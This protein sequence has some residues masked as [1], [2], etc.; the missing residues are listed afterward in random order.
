M[1]KLW[2]LFVKFYIRTGFAFYFKRVLV[3]G[4][5]N[6]PK[7]KA[8]LFV[9]NHQNALI[10]PL[11]IGSVSPRELNFLTRADVFNKRLVRWL[12][13]TVNMLPIYRIKDGI[14]SLSRN[15]EVFE[16]C[17]KILNNKGTVLIFPEGNHNI[18]R[19]LRIL[20]KGFTRIIFGTLKINPDLEIVVVPIG[21]NYSNAKKYASSVHLIFGEPIIV[22]DHHKESALNGASSQLKTDVSNA[23]KKLITHIEN[24][25]HHDTI[26]AKFHEEEF[27]HPNKVNQRISELG[28]E[29]E[30]EKTVESEFHLLKPLIHMNSFFPLLIWRKF[31]PKI[32]EEEFI[33]TYRFSMGISIFPLFYLLQ[34]FIVYLLLGSTASY[35]Y[36]AFSFL[37]VFLYVKSK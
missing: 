11:L 13:S 24:A 20:S 15:E 36:L 33:A 27:L 19:R 8:I 2:Y 32:V 37:I 1:K 35:F 31:Y 14:N 22:N 25:E 4:K 5:E 21:I 9:A 6:V 34:S 12:L 7:G 3:S 18:Q 17:Y 26:T 23:M 30:F 29:E 16:K 10:D 28:H